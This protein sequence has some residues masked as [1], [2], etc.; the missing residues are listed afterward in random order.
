MEMEIN[1]IN[2]YRSIDYSKHEYFPDKKKKSIPIVMKTCFSEE[3][4]I[5]QFGNPLPKRTPYF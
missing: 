1:V 2:N 3:K 5:K 4:L